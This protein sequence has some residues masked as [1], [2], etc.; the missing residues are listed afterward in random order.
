MANAKRLSG[1][2]SFQQADYS[3]DRFAAAVPAGTTLE[4]V[5][6]PEYFAGFIE[7]MRPRMRIEVLSADMQLD[8]E[9]R[10]LTVEKTYAKVRVLA[11]HSE[12]K[13]V[14]PKKDAPKG[15]GEKDADLKVSFGGPSHMWRFG[16][17]QKEP[18]EKGFGT[19]EE[20]EEALRNYLDR[21]AS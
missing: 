12:P 5:Q 11:V 8:C 17:D 3:I 16:E 9:L 19:K 14:A 18:V 7:K 4:D 21:K 1:S 10:V 15:A 20:A 6:D 13:A 2:S